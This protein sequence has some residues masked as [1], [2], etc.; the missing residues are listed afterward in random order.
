MKKVRP[1]VIVSPE[2]INSR[3]RT[4]IVVPMTSG[5]SQLTFRPRMEVD[6]RESVFAIDQ[7]RVIDRRRIAHR[8]SR[9]PQAQ[10][11]QLLTSLVGLFAP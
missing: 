11:A 1:C 6:G 2:K 10:L 8:I 4:V 7:L 9:I 5:G 3:L